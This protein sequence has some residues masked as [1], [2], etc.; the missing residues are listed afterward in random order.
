[1]IYSADR[2]ADNAQEAVQ[3]LMSIISAI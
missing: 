2:I 3:L 1:L